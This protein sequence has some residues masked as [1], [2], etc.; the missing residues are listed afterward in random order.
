MRDINTQSFLSDFDLSQEE[1]LRLEDSEEQFESLEDEE[2][3][4]DPLAWDIND[5][6][7]EQEIDS[8]AL[9]HYSMYGGPS[10][11]SPSLPFEEILPKNPVVE[12]LECLLSVAKHSDNPSFAVSFEEITEILLDLGLHL[13]NSVEKRELNQ[14]VFEDPFE[15]SDALGN[16]LMIHRQMKRPDTELLN[17]LGRELLTLATA[18]FHRQQLEEIHSEDIEEISYHIDPYDDSRSEDILAAKRYIVRLRKDNEQLDWR[19]GYLASLLCKKERSLWRLQDKI[20]TLYLRLEAASIIQA[21]GSKPS[22][23]SRKHCP[24]NVCTVEE[25]GNRKNQS[26]K[27]ECA[28]KSESQLDN[29]RW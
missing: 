28:K 10:Q 29:I 25:D 19:N 8:D 3:D 5:G 24:L 6:E 15:K 9:D 1:L 7:A 21:F 11:T 12:K 2:F 22:S 27:L 17:A 16:V 26:R 13:S 14:D 23:G 18:A 20:D 4:S